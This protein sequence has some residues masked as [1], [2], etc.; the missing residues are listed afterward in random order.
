[1][2]TTKK[3]D[4]AL[5]GQTRIWLQNLGR[6]DVL[7]GI[8]CYNNEGTIRNVVETVGEGLERYY[9]DLRTAILVSD[10]G[11]LDDTREE[12]DLAELSESV[13][14]KVVIYRGRPGKGTSFRAVFEAAALAH[15]KACIVV[16]SDLRSISPEWVKLLAG[17]VLEGKAGYVAPYYVRHKYDGTITNNIVYPMTR[18]LYGLRVRQPIGGDFGFCGELASLYARE[19][20][21]DT[22]VALFGIDVWMTTT[23]INEGFKVCQANLGAKVHDPKDPAADLGPMFRQVVCTLFYLMGEYEDNWVKAQGS[24]PVEM[25]GKAE[26]AAKPMDVKVNLDKLRAEFTEGFDQFKGLYGQVLAH[27]SFSQLERAV[28]A[29]RGGDVSLLGA[30]LWARILYDVAFVVQAWSRNRRR[31]VD[32]MT[33]LYFGRTAAYCQ[34]VADMD[35]AGAEAVVE[36]QAETFEGLKGYL[37]EKIAAWS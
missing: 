35:G 29:A 9:P 32:T 10:G 16:D 24:K 8:P 1:M 6:L 14:R 11:S 21:W 25:C 5:R 20:V 27:E 19:D 4:T 30:E 37:R 31:L 28:S 13:E 22:D 33:P 12:A 2:I 15:A 26:N 7:A 36:R 17:S 3:F 18:A 23:A 34:E